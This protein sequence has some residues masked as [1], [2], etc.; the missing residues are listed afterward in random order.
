VADCERLHDGL[1]DEPV[2]ALSSVAYIAAGIWV[3]R[4]DRPLG[5]ALVAVGVGS[6]AYHGF[7]GRAASWLHD[8]TIVALIIVVVASGRRIWRGARSRPVVAACAAGAFALAIPMQLFGRTGGPLCKPDSVLQAHGAWHVL[9]A[10][11]LACAF[12]VANRREGQA[13][14]AASH[15]PR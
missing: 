8:A 13:V 14:W 5:A 6:V 1:L 7:G 10:A 2:N 4:R 12:A 11:A 3:A 9:T 15:R